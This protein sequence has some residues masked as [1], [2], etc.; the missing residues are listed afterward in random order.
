MSKYVKQKTCTAIRELS[1]LIF[2]YKKK[3]FDCLFLCIDI[4]NVLHNLRLFSRPIVTIILSV[5]IYSITWLFL[6][7]LNFI[8]HWAI[9]SYWYIWYYSHLVFIHNS[10]IW[11]ARENWSHC[12]IWGAK[13]NTCKNLNEF[14]TFVE[15]ACPSFF[16]GCRKIV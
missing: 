16:V 5:K 7:Q 15:R 3:R 6:N 4:I 13:F 9:C 12:S 2:Y 1:I 11:I 14:S 10:I 8:K